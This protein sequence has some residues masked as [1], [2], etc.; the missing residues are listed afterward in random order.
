MPRRSLLAVWVLSLAVTLH[1][2]DKKAPE[3]HV[4]KPGPFRVSIELDG[5]FES[6]ESTEIQLDSEEWTNFEVE[7]AIDE[8][9]V[10]S[11]GD[12]LLKFDTEPLDD[13]IRELEVQ[14][15]LGELSIQQAELELNSLRQSVPLDLKAAEVALQLA[16]AELEYHEKY[17]EDL[18]RE[19]AEYA[20]KSSKYNLESAQEELNQLEQMYKADD[21][22]EETE[23]IILK[24]A[25]RSV[26]S[27]K[28]SLEMAKARY[29]ENIKIQLPR[30]SDKVRE[31]LTRQQIAWE[32]ARLELPAS[33]TQKELALE[34]LRHS[35]KTLERKL[36]RLQHDQ[37]L[38]EI[39]APVD[40]M[41]YYGQAER[42][43]WTTGATLAKQMRKAG[44]LPPR[45]VV[46]TIVPEGHLF[47]RADVP[48]A[49]L[50]H[51]KPDGDS[52][53]IP[54]AWPDV[55]LAA[56]VVEI[57]PIASSPGKFDA[58]LDLQNMQ[59]V[60]DRLQPG[61]TGKARLTVF[62]SDSAVSV[63]ASAVFTDELDPDQRYVYLDRDGKSERRDVEVGYQ[64]GDNL[65]ITAGLEAGDRIRLKKP[66]QE[67]E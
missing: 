30:K 7:T 37:E 29:D 40:G 62:K 38:M 51:V 63:P 58:R 27:A 16:R 19:S 60:P 6:S 43:R 65:Q 47:F 61:M 4:V 52:V 46:L 57:D 23:E 24:R 33:V 18:N 26:E 54:T 45:S 32:K 8:G 9:S 67:S 34:K 36:R 39:T 48:E 14:I 1:A 21:L 31:D 42:G 53:L 56:R 2:D 20:L 28:L 49:E 41:V 66:E 15:R 11:K 35:Q 13:Q 10:V 12:V 44:T 55:R 59:D 5:V 22:T 64:S 3:V 17:W 50:R 25:R